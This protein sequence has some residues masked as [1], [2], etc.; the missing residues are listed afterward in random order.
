MFVADAS[1][2]LTWFLDSKLSAIQQKV[3]AAVGQLVATRRSIIIVPPLWLTETQ[4]V[5]LKLMRQRRI[6]EAEAMNIR[7]GLTLLVVRVDTEFDQDAIDRTWEF[8]TQHMLTFYDACYLELAWR[9]KLPLASSDS[10]LCRAAKNL[11]I[12][13]L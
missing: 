9:L 4:N 12:P 11:N 6:N 13:L 2:T 3:W 5:I 10:A 1:T 7:I 8:A